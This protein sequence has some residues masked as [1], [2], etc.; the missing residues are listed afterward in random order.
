MTTQRL[1]QLLSAANRRSL[2]I[3]YSEDFL[4]PETRSAYEGGRALAKEFSRVGIPVDYCVYPKWTKSLEGSPLVRKAQD[5]VLE[6]AD[7]FAI[8]EPSPNDLV[9]VKHTISL[10]QEGDYKPVIES[11]DTPTIIVGGVLATACVKY[12]MRDLL[13]LNETVNII[14]AQDAINLEH[15]T[16]DEYRQSIIEAARKFGPVNEDRIISASNDDLIL[17]L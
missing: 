4:I 13:R 14:I 8:V 2:M 16:P 12:T 10:L 17:S 7:K 5:L 9:Y 3:D 11:L 15:H 6:G 1:K